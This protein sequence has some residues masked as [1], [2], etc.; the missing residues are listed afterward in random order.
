MERIRLLQYLYHNKN[1]GTLTRY[2]AGYIN[3]GTKIYKNT[4][5]FLPHTAYV[6]M[7]AN[8]KKEAC[9]KTPFSMK[10]LDLHAKTICITIVQASIALPVMLQL[11][12]IVRSVSKKHLSPLHLCGRM[13]VYIWSARDR[14]KYLLDLPYDAPEGS[15][16]PSLQLQSCCS[17]G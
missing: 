8:T 9:I 15:T 4:L 11:R 5:K 7:A 17:T 3:P 14:F 2:P 1:Q 10:R 6:R 13:F 12:M 16:P